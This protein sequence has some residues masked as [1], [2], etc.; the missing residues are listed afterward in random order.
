LVVW[1]VA[2]KV[3]CSVG[4][5]AVSRA[6]R[7]ADW[8]AARTDVWWVVVKVYWWAE[9][10]VALK[11]GYLAELTVF[12]TAVELVVSMVARLAEYLADLSVSHWA[13]GMVDY[14]AFQWVVSLVD[15]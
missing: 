4:S 6:A 12:W 5:W 15:D 2:Q 11:A 7:T 13:V 9:Q 1:T 3:D 14:L 8:S 10:K